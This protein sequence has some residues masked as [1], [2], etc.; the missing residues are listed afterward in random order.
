MV[1]STDNAVIVRAII[2]LAHN[3]SRK[4]VAEGVEDEATMRAQIASG[5]D[6]AQG[7]HFSRPLFADD[8]ALWLETS[9]FGCRRSRPGE[10]AA[11]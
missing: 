10:I 7:Y 8:L 3:L 5:C 4:V 1:E 11:P 6:S 2:D 9:P